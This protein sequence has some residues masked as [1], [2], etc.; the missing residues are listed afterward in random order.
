[1]IKIDNELYYLALLITILISLVSYF[2]MRGIIWSIA[3]CDIRNRRKSVEFKKEFKKKKNISMSYLLEYVSK[4]QSAYN[5]W[6]TVKKIFIL[7][8]IIVLLIYVLLPLTGCPLFIPFLLNGI[9]CAIW[10]LIVNLQFDFN[11]NTKYDK[12]WIFKHDSNLK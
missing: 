5:F 11:R 8:E 4:Y 1:M 12:T 10:F 6:M 2:L 9:Q 7:F 3:L